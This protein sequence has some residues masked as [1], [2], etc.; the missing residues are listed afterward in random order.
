M[1]RLH[2]WEFVNFMDNAQASYGT[3][4]KSLG[5]CRDNIWA[6]LGNYI[7]IEQHLSATWYSF[8]ILTWSN[9][10]FQVI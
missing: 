6:S 10:N 9:K 7:D 8:E 4:W 5:N 3:T 1:P 2:D